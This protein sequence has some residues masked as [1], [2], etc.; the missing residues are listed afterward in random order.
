M[1]E[2]ARSQTP[3]ALGCEYSEALYDRARSPHRAA[4]S[5]TRVNCCVRC[6]VSPSRT[7]DHPACTQSPPRIGRSEIS[8]CVEYRGSAATTRSRAS[9]GV[10]EPSITRPNL[11]RSATLFSVMTR[12]AIS[13]PSRAANFRK[14]S[15][16]KNSGTGSSGS[17]P[18]M[19]PRSANCRRS[20]TGS[21]LV[22]SQRIIGPSTAARIS[23][24]DFAMSE[25][26]F[27]HTR[28]DCNLAACAPL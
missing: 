11:P 14:N 27:A 12:A 1:V 6:I 8:S 28:Y 19:Y 2:D 9:R 20:W 7:I 17:S 24:M 15:N 18:E 3:G 4:V 10:R 21:P 16:T 23:G 25:K 22:R 26:T 13:G 5:K